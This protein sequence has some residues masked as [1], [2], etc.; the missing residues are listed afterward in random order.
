MECLA[1]NVMLYMVFISR[2][3][4]DSLKAL[5]CLELEVTPRM[6]TPLAEIAHDVCTFSVVSVLVP[7]GPHDL[8]P[9]IARRFTASLLV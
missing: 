5:G 9:K 4:G 3:N 2:E 7:L 8:A 6:R 1:V